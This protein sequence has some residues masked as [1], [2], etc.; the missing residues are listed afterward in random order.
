VFKPTLAAIKGV[1]Y[2]YLGNSYQVRKDCASEDCS[3]SFKELAGRLMDL[4]HGGP[5]TVTITAS[6]GGTSATNQAK[7]SVDKTPVVNVSLPVGIVSS[8]FDIIGLAN[9]KPT[10]QPTKG[11]LYVYL[12]N[13]YLGNKACTTESCSYSYKEIYGKLMNLNPGGPHK[14]RMYASGSGVQALDEESFTVVA[15]NLKAVS[16]AADMDT[17]DPYAAGAVNFSGSLSDDSNRTIKW[18]VNV[19]SQVLSGDGTSVL[20]AWDGKSSSGKMVEP[21]TYLATLTAQTAEGTCSAKETKSVPV[22][23]ESQPEDPSLLACFGSTVN[24]ASGNLRH[25]QAL[26]PLPRSKLGGDFVLTYNSLDGQSS[27]MATGWTHTY[28]ITLKKNNNGSYTLVEGD[29]RRIALYSQGGRYTP[30]SSNYPALT[31]LGDGTA[32]LEH[33]EG[34]FYSFDSV[35][36]ITNISDR[37]SNKLT[38]LYTDGNLTGITDPSE[39]TISIGYDQNNRIQA[40]TD[41]NGNVHSFSYTDGNLIALSSQVQQLGL[42][43]WAYSYYSNGFL[44][45]KTDPMGNKTEY[46]YDNQYRVAKV[47]DPEG[48]TREVIYDPAHSQTQFI[49]KDGGLWT[50]KYDPSLGVLKEKTDPLQNPTSYTYYPDRNLKSATD[51]RGYT[52]SYTYDANANVTSVEDASGHVTK[53][54]Y[55]SFNKVA[56]IELDPKEPLINFSY[57]ERGNLKKVVD[58]IGMEREYEYDSRG[59]L[60]VIKNALEKVGLEYNQKDDLTSVKD[61]VSGLTLYEFDYDAIG[62]RTSLKE[63]QKTGQET[64]KVTRFEYNG[65]N[66]VTRTTGPPPELNQT[67][68]DYDPNGNIRS[69]LDANGNSTW[70]EH[71]YQG[72]VSKVT[73]A[74]GYETFLKYGT[75]CPSCGAGVDKLTSVIDARKQ[76]TAFEYDQAGNLGKETDPLGYSTSYKYDS[77]GNLRSRTDANGN[78]TY[79]NFD[80]LK[81]L[82]EIQY[83]DQTTAIYSYDYRGNLKTA[84]NPHI[85]YT[86]TYDLN[87]RLTE[88]I[89]SEG[90]SISYRYNELGNRTRM[91]TPDGRVIEYR[92]DLQNHLTKVLVDSVP[93]V[94]F[95]HDPYG[96]RLGLGY[97]NGAST[98]YSYNPSGHLTDL[99]ARDSK[100]STINYF[101]YTHD[102]VGNRKTMTDLTGAHGY[103]Y[104]KIYQLARATHLGMP[105]EQFSY[106]PVGNRLGTAVDLDNALL[107][108]NDYSYAYDYNGNLIEKVSKATGE[109]TGYSYDFENRLIKVE[110]SGVL[111][112][113]KYDPFGRRIEKN[114]NGTITRYCYDGPNILL[115][116]DGEGNIKS[117]YLHNL[118]IDDI[119][120][121][122][123]AGKVYYYQ[124]DALGSVVALT[125]EAGQ[126]VQTYEYDS[127]GKITNQTG[128]IRN[129]FTFTGREYDE[130][131]TL[132]YYRARYYDPNAGRF[133]TKDPIG[134]AGGDV[135]LYRMVVNNPV[136]Y[137]DPLGLWPPEIHNKIIWEAFESLPLHLRWAIEEGSRYADTFQDPKD[138]YMH[139]MRSKGQTVGEAQRAMENFIEKHINNYKCEKEKGNLY[140][141]FFQ[142]G[143]ALHPVMDSTSP[144]HRGLQVWNGLSDMPGHWLAEREISRQQLQESVKNINR[145]LFVYGIT[146]K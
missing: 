100:Q 80:E 94:D 31:V 128:S 51:P 5:Y 39:R 88:V 82:K 32:T 132:Y 38:L 113:Y 138:A 104:D 59:N 137:R 21:D 6:G 1:I 12:D 9:F 75:G 58:Q 8:P 140:D 69:V 25:S 20:A 78:T 133:L 144:S 70:Y 131:T 61:L 123:Q 40:I 74:L 81:R 126:V 55:N 43:N 141:A 114:V 13:Y 107:E 67:R 19:G 92:Y 3:Y 14:V 56:S 60:T 115:E 86:F 99:L 97:A 22:T 45:T 33:K 93:Y 127:F 116:Y 47:I 29:G 130:E 17:F 37:N 54:T 23:I 134:F 89:D 11:W 117:R 65:L 73:D 48:R 63:V 44:W 143:M 62:N 98:S 35:G 87:N 64:E 76:T 18:K 57:D 34:I 42:Q 142:L 135:N 118:A 24:L 119:L 26:F 125:D 27:P 102:G 28:N 90:R 101:A 7:F 46:F 85:A 146:L 15:C 139:A 77:A 136:N 103:D 72:K 49:E 52:T 96:R 120:A 110:S 53:Y 129:P 108:D 30:K 105:E 95:T 4:N 66:R 91:V 106:D 111:V 41:P 145:T 121:M 84:A 79:H 68:Y 122:E 109:K 10:L 50:Y 71:N 124:K 83:P 36:K 16:L 2:F 112:Q